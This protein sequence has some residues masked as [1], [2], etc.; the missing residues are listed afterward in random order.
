MFLNYISK[1]NCFEC[2]CVNV[3][4]LCYI[5]CIRIVYEK[6]MEIRILRILMESIGSI[7]IY[8]M[9]F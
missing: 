1:K 3:L 4:N 7:F 6:R 8:Y 5:M 2:F 9:E